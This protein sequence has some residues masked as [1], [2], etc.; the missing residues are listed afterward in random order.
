MFLVTISIISCLFFFAIV[1]GYFFNIYV[2][3]TL[4]LLLSALYVWDLSR[5]DSFPG[6][7]G[8]VARL[9]F[10]MAVL[11]PFVITMVIT[12]IVVNQALVASF[13]QT[14]ARYLSVFFLR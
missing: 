10:E 11:V 8:G 13:F 7:S 2:V 5:P 12:S 14:I 4:A 6:T 1:A 3:F 9:M